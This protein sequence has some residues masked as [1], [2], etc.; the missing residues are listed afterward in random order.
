MSTQNFE[1]DATLESH[2]EDF[3]CWH[4]V[5]FMRVLYISSSGCE[6]LALSTVVH[7]DR[8]TAQHFQF[9]KSSDHD[10]FVSYQRGAATGTFCNGIFS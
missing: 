9:C 8:M 3:V 6:A 1:Q 7:N 10:S 5:K 2:N 4:L